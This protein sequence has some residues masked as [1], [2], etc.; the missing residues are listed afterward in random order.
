ML[1]S[2]LSKNPYKKSFFAHEDS[3][4]LV[5]T[6]I[7]IY[8]LTLSSNSL[9]IVIPHTVIN[10]FW[11]LS[12]MNRCETL[13]LPSCQESVNCTNSFTLKQLTAAIRMNWHSKWCLSDSLRFEEKR[14]KFR[15]WLQ[16]IVVKLNVNMLNNNVSVQFWYL[17]SQLKGLTLS[18]VTSWIVACIK[19]NKVLNHTI[20]EKLINQ[21][22]HAYNDS[23]LKKRVTGTLKALKQ[24]KKPFA[25]HLTTFK[26]MLLKAEGLKWNDA[27][28]KTFLN[29]SLDATLMWALIVTSISVLYDEYITL[30]QQVSYNLDSIQKAVTQECCTTT[31]IITQQSHMNNMNWELTEHII[32]TALKTE[33]R[34]REQWMSEKK[35]T[36]CHT[37]QLCM[38]CKDND[39]FIKN[40]KLLSA[41][42]PCVINV[43]TAETVKKM[44]EEEKN[45]KKE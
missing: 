15:P 31:I 10:L 9:C 20:I 18:Q 16:Q 45:S 38:H 7:K 32:V 27:V 37:K 30:L 43:V 40:C 6:L 5:L 11:H 39:H 42:Q 35:V 28:K 36:K 14:V 26:Q 41:V 34:C 13:Q 2:M 3:S 8:G 19:S 21:L 44:T 1:L 33:E 24:K 29:N 17:H 22:Q 25:K 23:E 12:E 4:E